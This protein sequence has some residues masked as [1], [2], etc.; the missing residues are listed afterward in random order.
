MR[1]ATGFLALEKSPEEQGPVSALSH[2]V[3]SSGPSVP[4]CG[5]ATSWI[6]ALFQC[7]LSL[8]PLTALLL[9]VLPAWTVPARF[10]TRIQLP[11]TRQ[12][13]AKTVRLPK[14]HYF[15]TKCSPPPPT[16]TDS[17]DSLLLNI[18]SDCLLLLMEKIRGWLKTRENVWSAFCR[19]GRSEINVSQG[20]APSQ[21]PGANSVECQFLQLAR[22]PQCFLAWRQH[23]CDMGTV[24]LSSFIV[25]VPFEWS[26]SVSTPFLV[27]GAEWY[28]PGHS[29]DL[30]LITTAKT[31]FPSKLTFQGAG[32]RILFIIPPQKN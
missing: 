32:T 19:S 14:G 31:L 6:P 21:L 25:C 8:L 2:R 15:P 7:F 13:S 26:I 16:H 12:T 17:A 29:K 9:P 4:L 30:T 3:P 22:N 11:F 23:S 5:S 20:H 27:R 18:Y 10:L 1:Q 28:F 24:S